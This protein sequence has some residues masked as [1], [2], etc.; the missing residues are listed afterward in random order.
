MQVR[1]TANRFAP[2]NTAMTLRSTR[3]LPCLAL[4]ALLATS[5]SSSSGDG[6][7]TPPAQTIAATLQ[8]QGLTTLRDA[9]QQTGLLS[10]LEGGT[11]TLFA[12]TNAAFDALPSGLL[13]SL[14]TPQL[15][16]VLL[17]HL[18][19][20]GSVPSSVAVTLSEATMANGDDVILDVIGSALFVNEARVTQADVTASNGVIHILDRVLLPPLST[21][22]T[23]AQR[24]E[25]STLIGALDAIGG[26]SLQ[27]LLGD[28]QPLTLLAPTDAAFDLLPP[29]LLDGLSI[30]ELTDILSYHVVPGRVVASQALLG[31]LAASL[32]GPNLL[33]AGGSSPTVN[34]IGISLVNVPTLDGV[35]HVLDAVLLPPDT[36]AGTAAE[37]T[38]FDTLLL[39]LQV[40]GLDTPFADPGAGPFTVFAPTDAAFAALPPGL[41]DDLVNEP[42]TPTLIQILTY[43]VANDALTANAVIAAVGT[44]IPTL[45]GTSL[46]V[47]LVGDGVQVDQ[48]N[49]IVPNVLCSNGIVHAI[50][51]VLLPAGIVLP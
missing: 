49:V 33:F 3:S 26:L 23:L 34:G 7:A 37:L 38:G 20:G 14:T 24:G 32:L 19:D 51:A 16:E 4:V 47:T 18:F 31:E 28:P 41:L 1:R 25:F 48:A 21:P 11:Q 50:D 35:I 46:S 22:E 30:P 5:C 15:T 44:G 39:A 40:A 36:I 12:P 8:S 2:R 9:L 10:A 6:S 29:G 13:A 17:Y 43:H 42:G 27:G 45:E